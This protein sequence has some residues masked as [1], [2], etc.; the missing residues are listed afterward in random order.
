MGIPL[1]SFFFLFMRLLA[2]INGGSQHDEYCKVARCSPPVDPSIRFPFWLKHWQPDHCGYLGFEISCSEKNQTLL[3][4]PSSL[5]KLWA[6]KINYTS[7]DMVVRHMDDHYCLQRRH[8]ILNL[9]T[10]PFHFTY[11]YSISIDDFSFKCSENKAYDQLNI[12]IP[13]SFFSSNYNPVYATP[14]YVYLTDVNLTSY[15]KIFNATLP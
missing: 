7:Q 1:L 6:K 13:C 10:S 8:H 14:S 5:V 15:R 9:S 12:S 4:L 3:E 11:D 2:E